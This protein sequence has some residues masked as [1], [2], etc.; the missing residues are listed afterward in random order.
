[1]PILSGFGYG[2]GGIQKAVVSSST[3]NSVTPVTVG[4]LPAKVYRFIG[5]GSITFARAGLVDILLVGPGGAAGANQGSGGAGG[6]I[7][8]TNVFVPIG[9]QSIIVGAGY[10]GA[11]TDSFNSGQSTQFMQYAAICG[12]SGSAY[13]DRSANSGAGGGGG[14]NADG[15]TRFSALVGFDGIEGQGLIGSVNKGGRGAGAPWGGGGGATGN[16]GNYVGGSG[17]TTSF[18]GS[19][20]TF[21][22]GGGVNS[23]GAGQANTGNGG[24]SGSGGSGIA[25]IRVFD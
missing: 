4:G 3:A 20:Q 12:G 22:I 17:A 8:K 9:T 25:F 24:S 21:C 7:E 16:G 18:P 13:Y 10:G 5:S 1:M 6:F 19:S 14:G 15:R 11:T 23:G 2:S